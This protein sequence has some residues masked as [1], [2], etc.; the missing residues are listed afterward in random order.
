MPISSQKEVKLKTLKAPL[1][2]KTMFFPLVNYSALPHEHP[3]DARIPNPI[4]ITA[5]PKCNE[6]YTEC[7]VTLRIKSEVSSEK[8]EILYEYEIVVFGSF[9]WTAKKPEDEDYLL[10][11]IAVTGASILYS[12]AREMLA[13]IS[14]RGPW[15]PC[16]LPA[17]SFTPEIQIENPDQEATPKEAGT[18]KQG[19]TGARKTKK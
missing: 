5:I 14:T 11:S 4:T 15:K 12:G 16:L 8:P 6:D 2:L 9:E 1:R 3:E 19:K 18:P 17:V 10:K 7:S 13:Q